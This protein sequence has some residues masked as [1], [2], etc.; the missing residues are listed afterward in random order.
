ME[1]R[2][3]K[4]G[5]ASLGVVIDFLARERPFAAMRAGDLLAAVTYQLTWTQHF[6][7][8]QE[9]RL[10]AYCGWLTTT[11]ERGEAW[12][13][14]EGRIEP[15][16]ASAGDAAA[17]TIVKVSHDSQLLP[18]IRACRDHNKGKRVFFKRDYAETGK[19]S[20]KS[21]VINRGS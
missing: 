17:L 1:I 3:L 7:G 10:V 2:Q 12:V 19:P 20:R 5:F 6:A 15:L 13:K 16:P 4:P 14:G 11:A 21:T 18:M 9:G 8:F